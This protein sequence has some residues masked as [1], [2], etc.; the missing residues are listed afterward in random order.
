[1]V[2]IH[3]PMYLPWLGYFEKMYRCDAFVLLDDAA[4]SRNYFIN[5]N[6][7]RTKEGWTWLTVPV[8][9]TGKAGQPIREVMVD[10]GKRWQAKHWKSMSYSYGQ[11]PHFAGHEG[12]FRGF[13]SREH[14]RLNDVL[15][16][17][18]EYLRDAFGIRTRILLSSDLGVPGRK[19]E[20]LLAICR[21]LGADSYLSGP[22]G[23]DYLDLSRWKE[24]GIEVFFHDYR[25]PVYPQVQGGFFPEMSAV[26]LLFNC[27]GESL[28][29]LSES[30]PA[31]GATRGGGAA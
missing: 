7:I 25:N 8:L 27:G 23:R 13:Y 20:R 18:M 24:E 29:V 31:Y 9:S 16:E 12:F 15:M 2:G 17:P 26:D 21:Q 11:A 10:Q 30:Q 28:R 22:S 5:R 6:R 4:Y 3:Q 19:A 14:A 1:M